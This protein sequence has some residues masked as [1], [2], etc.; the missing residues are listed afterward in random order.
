MG[1]DR[2]GRG[3]RDERR[4]VLHLQLR[5]ALGHVPLD[6]AALQNGDVALLEDGV[7]APASNFSFQ[8]SGFGFRIRVSWFLVFGSVVFGVWDFGVLG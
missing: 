1:C 3:A 2:E 6:R 7:R 4:A 8:F 5:V